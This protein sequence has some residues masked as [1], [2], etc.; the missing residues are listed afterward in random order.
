LRKLEK[1]QGRAE[2]ENLTSK[3]LELT[4]ISYKILR[5]IIKEPKIV[6]KILR[7]L[8]RHWDSKVMVIEESE[9]LRTLKYDELVG[10]LLLMSSNED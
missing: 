3:I 7:S 6:R 1:N 2:K 10:L 8:P 4:K 5:K 9:D